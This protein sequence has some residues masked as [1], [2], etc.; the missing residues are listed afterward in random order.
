MQSNTDNKNVMEED[1][2]TSSNSKSTSLL[3]SKSETDDE[4][5]SSSIHS[6]VKQSKT[7]KNQ[8]DGDRGKTKR[9]FVASNPIIES[10]KTIKKFFAAEYNENESLNDFE[11]PKK[12]A[13]KSSKTSTTSSTTTARKVKTAKSRNKKLPD[14]RKIL[15]KQQNGID[16]DEDE[17]LQLA[18]ELSKIESNERN[19]QGNFEQFDYKPKN[20]GK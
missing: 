7:I 20:D 19:D 15:R 12:V 9:L 13:R 14:I 6:N 17:E 2:T 10:N 18:V 8:F 16:L 3:N 5:Y 11:I 4:A 1:P